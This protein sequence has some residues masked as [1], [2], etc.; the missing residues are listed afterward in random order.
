MRG[1][2]GHEMIDQHWVPTGMARSRLARASA[3]YGD[4]DAGRRL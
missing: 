4:H 2:T 1:S 3:D